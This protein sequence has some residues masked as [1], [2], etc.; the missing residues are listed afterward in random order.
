MRQIVYYQEEVLLTNFFIQNLKLNPTVNFIIPEKE[1]IL[2]K[3]AIIFAF[4][5]FAKSFFLKLIAS[6]L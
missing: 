3:E 4:F 2:F 1:I 5:R 6:Q